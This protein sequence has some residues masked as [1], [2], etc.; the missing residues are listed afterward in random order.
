MRK[1]TVD[2]LAVGIDDAKASDWHTLSILR[3]LDGA[4]MYTQLSVMVELVEYVTDQTEN[5]IVG[6]LGGDTAQASDV[7]AL[8]GKIVEAATPKN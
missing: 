3:M 1:V 6:H 7:V 8:L 5:S 4:N 2:G